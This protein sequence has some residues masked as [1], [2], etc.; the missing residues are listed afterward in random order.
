M[1]RLGGDRPGGLRRVSSLN[2]YGAEDV[3]SLVLA[4]YDVS[5]ESFTT[6]QAGS[7]FLEEVS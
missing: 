3:K 1:Y 5:S 2:S 6:S 4:I 7:C